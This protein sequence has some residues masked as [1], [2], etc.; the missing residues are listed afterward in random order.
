MLKIEENNCYKLLYMLGLLAGIKSQKYPVR[1]KCFVKNI[2]GFIQSFT[3]F[4]KN[5]FRLFNFIVK[6]PQNKFLTFMGSFINYV[7]NFFK[8]ECLNNFLKLL[9]NLFFLKK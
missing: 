6:Y 9:R 2:F 7:R 3:G 4:L 8:F 1:L 5:I